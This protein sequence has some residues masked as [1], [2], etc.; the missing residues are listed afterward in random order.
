VAAIRSSSCRVADFELAVSTAVKARTI[1]TGQS[2]I[3]AKRFFIAD[4]I[5]DDFLK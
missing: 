4:K 3:A 2:C 5:Y 1:N